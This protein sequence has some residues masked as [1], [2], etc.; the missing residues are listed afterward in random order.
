MT[1][2]WQKTEWPGFC[3][4]AGAI[5]GLERAF[6]RDSGVLE[7]TY[8]HLAEA[9][10][11]ELT[12]SLISEEACQTSAIEGE[13]L[14]RDSVQSSIRKELGLAVAGNNSSPAETGIAEMNFF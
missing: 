12:V 4:D 3:F 11:S 9:E 1:W 8:R 6:L 10:K 2:N 14:N 5:E 13:I 7:G